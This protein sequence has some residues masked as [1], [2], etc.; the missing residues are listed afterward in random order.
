MTIIGCSFEAFRG[1]S[2]RQILTVDALR[3]APGGFAAWM[4][5]TNKRPGMVRLREN[6]AYA[7]EVAARLI[8]EKRQEA[9]DGTSRRDVLTLLG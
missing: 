7:H 5:E 6:R 3:W 8:E 2:K 9:K 4:F 1:A